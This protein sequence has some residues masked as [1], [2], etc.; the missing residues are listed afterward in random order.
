MSLLNNKDENDY[1]LPNEDVKIHRRG[2]EDVLCL[3][4]I[5]NLY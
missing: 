5:Q 2:V 1:D 3:E 4:I